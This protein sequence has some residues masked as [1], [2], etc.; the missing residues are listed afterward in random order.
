M[1]KK[2]DKKDKG[3][4]GPHE[5][6]LWKTVFRINEF[7]QP[8]LEEPPGA[9]PRPKVPPEPLTLETMDEATYKRALDGIFL[10]HGLETAVELGLVEG[11]PKELLRRLGHDPALAEL[12]R[13]EL[14]RCHEEIGAYGGPGRPKKKP[15]PTLSQHAVAEALTAVRDYLIQHPGCVDRSRKPA[16]YSGDFKEFIVALLRPGGLAG[17]ATPEQA[18]FITGL[19]RV[20][21]T[22]WLREARTAGPDTSSDDPSDS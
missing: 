16:F 2:D 7:G 6:E 13:P 10:L 9:P 3:P 4:K 19:P 15:T 20:T 11:D 17:G 12:A 1:G 8:V 18:Q 21:L 14:H 5:P 22:T